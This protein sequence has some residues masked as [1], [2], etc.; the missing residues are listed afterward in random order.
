MYIDLLKLDLREALSDILIPVVVLAATYPSKQMVEKTWDK[1]LTK[2][3]KKTVY[4][5]ENAAHFIM[6]DQ[7]EW[8]ITK[9][10]ENL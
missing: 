7:P 10:K 8:L 6:F 5:A 4:Y 1:Q 2:L 9:I 3:N